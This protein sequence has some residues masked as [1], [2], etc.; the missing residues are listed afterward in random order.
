[1][2][3]TTAGPRPTSPQ[4]LVNATPSCKLPGTA[5]PWQVVRQ[6]AAAR[7]LRKKRPH[8]GAI[9]ALDPAA[10]RQEFEKFRAG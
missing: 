4:E 6:L 1:M 9:R 2:R 7:A 10:G 5:P 8:P 3:A